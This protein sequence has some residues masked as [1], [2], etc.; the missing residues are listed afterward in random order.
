[1]QDEPGSQRPSVG[2][3]VVNYNG[4]A[5]IGRFAESLA[6]VDYANRRIVIVDNASTDG[7]DAELQ[8]L[9][10]DTVLLRAPENLGTAGGNNIGI[11]YCLD[12][13]FDRILILNND[14][15]LTETFLS[16]LVAFADERTIAVPKILYYDDHR[17]I[18]TH[19]G[20]FDW[21]FGLFSKTFHGK[22]DGPATSR[23]RD[24]QTASFCCALVPATA[25]R[26]AGLL[27]ERFFMYY[28]ETDWLRRALATGFRLRYDPEAVVYHM[29]SASSGG[30]WMTPFKHYYA[31]RNRLYL[32]HKNSRSRFWFAVFTAYFLATRLVYLGR[33]AIKRDRPM[34]KALLRGVLDYYR[35]RMG[36]TLEVEQLRE[37]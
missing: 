33:H 3:V 2:I 14:T 10:P 23:P 11:R 7:S 1:M 15:V 16:K 28:E 5:F 6:R 31:T 4:A 35:G 26:E 30:G 29:E 20:D 17:L 24:L 8:R 19:A 9:L 25:F 36:R 27:D 22:P 13:G 12:E 18:S 21:R 34:V 37:T 32:V